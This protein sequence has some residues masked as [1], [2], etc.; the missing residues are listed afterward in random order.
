M[1]ALAINRDGVSPRRMASTLS[2]RLA[3]QR[4]VGQALRSIRESRDPRP[5]LRD[6][7]SRLD[8]SGAAYQK[9]EVGETRID[10][11][12][13]RQVLAALESDLEELDL[14]KA[15]ILNDAEPP[16]P[17]NDLRDTT[18]GFEINVY[19]RARAGPQGMEVYDVGAPLRTISLRSLMGPRAD[20]FEVAGES[21]SPWA[22]PGEI[23]VFDRDRYPKRGQ[24]C[25]IEMKSGQMLLKQYAKTDASQLFVREL[26]PEDRTFAISLRDVV[27]VYA[28]TVRGG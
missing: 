25:V 21:M 14:A 20:A 18:R 9:Y 2:P 24:G 23:V 5:T 19:G 8:M 10:A 6:I 28:V 17:A 22:E 12:R 15:K 11:E 3:E 16:S 27:G 7:G 26:Q 13:L 4:L 1:L